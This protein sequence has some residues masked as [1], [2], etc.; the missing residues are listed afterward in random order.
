MRCKHYNVE[1]YELYLTRTA[2]FFSDGEV[3]GHS[4]DPEGDYTGAV[5][6]ECPDCGMSKRFRGSRKP[7]WL[8]KYLGLARFDNGRN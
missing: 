6:V 7:K 4:C 1:I 5:D 8:R 3:V 2:H